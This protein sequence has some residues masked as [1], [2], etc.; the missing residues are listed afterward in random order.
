VSDREF[1]SDDL[2]DPREILEKLK[3]NLRFIWLGLGAIVVLVLG[4]GSFFQVE[5]EEVAIVLRFG[6]PTGQEFGPG[7]H[8]KLPIVDQVFKEAVERQHRLEFGF[9]SEPGEVTKVTETGFD[10]ESLMLTGDLQLVQVRWSLIYQIDEIETWLFEV[11]DK[12]ATI[13]DIGMAVMRQLVGDY[14]L[15]EVLTVKVRE[16]QNLAAQETQKAL[17]DK[18]PTGV[19]ITE[20]AIRGTDVPAGA[21]EIFDEFNRTEPDIRRELD[22]AKTALEKVTGEAQKLR[23]QA[24]GGAEKQKAEIELNAEGEARA[25][26]AQ[27]AEFEQAPEI[28]RQWMYLQTMTKVLAG[29][30]DKIIIDD[31][32]TGGDTLKLLPLTDMLQGRQPARPAVEAGGAR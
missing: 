21:K 8:F 18:V 2:P 3:Q 12:E 22:E 20:L 31:K 11:K 23:E 6:K 4:F 10:K 26:L 15:H 7:L 32:G 5:P 13:R 28:T 24:V 9:R 29:V 1:G 30:D 25:F 14:S 16:L 19:Q 17:R 27:L